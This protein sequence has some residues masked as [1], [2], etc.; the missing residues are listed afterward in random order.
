MVLSKIRI[1]ISRVM[2]SQT[3]RKLRKHQTQLKQL[4]QLRHWDL[5]GRDVNAEVI[6]P[7]QAIALLDPFFTQI[8]A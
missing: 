2:P 7:Q 8:V 5:S 6:S 3:Q 1:T 4:Q